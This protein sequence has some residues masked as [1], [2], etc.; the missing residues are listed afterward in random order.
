[1]PSDRSNRELA[2]SVR[3]G[4]ARVGDPLVMRS[5]SSQ[6]LSAVRST[7][8]P[9]RGPL[10][11][12]INSSGAAAAVEQFHRR[13]GTYGRAIA[14][15]IQ[16]VFKSDHPLARVAHTP[17]LYAYQGVLSG[18]S[19]LDSIAI[20][21]AH[22][23]PVLILVDSDSPGD[24]RLR[25]A[26]LAPNDPTVFVELPKRYHSRALAFCPLPQAANLGR[27]QSR[28]S[29]YVA[30]R[31]V[32]SEWAF[33]EDL[34]FAIANSSSFGDLLCIMFARLVN[35]RLELPVVVVRH[36]DIA[37]AFADAYREI[38]DS[39]QELMAAAL[40]PAAQRLRKLGLFVDESPFVNI[41]LWSVCS[42]CGRRRARG[43]GE[44][45]LDCCG[46]STWLPRLA[47]DGIS[48]WMIWG[49]RVGVTYPGSVT[50]ALL[51]AALHDRLVGS[52]WLD[53]VW[54][55]AV[56]D[57]HLDR[58]SREHGRSSVLRGACSVGPVEWCR[59]WDGPFRDALA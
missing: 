26:A 55:G 29:C 6:P 22:A 11:G 43:R 14:E 36:S 25:R 31:G 7:F 33:E 16:R 4:Q 15:N 24:S 54:A 57:G 38:V 20:S 30:T 1:M 27:F 44:G 35:L 32:G 37:S 9:G 39:G 48:D 50:Q 13:A 42:G 5:L 47:V 23:V 45:A 21:G 40:S 34:E 3:R 49:F 56:A 17:D 28:L 18:L 8:E 53:L 10:W 58:F 59:Q 12:A 19:L 41:G 2:L 52:G 51:L 46:P